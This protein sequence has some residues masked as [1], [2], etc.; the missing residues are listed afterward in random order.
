LLEFIK[1]YYPIFFTSIILFFTGNIAEPISYVILIVVVVYWQ[2]T[3][4]PHLYVMMAFVLLIF[5]DSRLPQLAFVKNLRYIIIIMLSVQVLRDLLSKKYSYNPLLNWAIPFFLLSSLSLFLSP[6][7]VLSFSKMVSYYLLLFVTLHLLQYY[8]LTSNG[9]MLLDL[10]KLIIWIFL[11]GLMLYVLP[12]ITNYKGRFRG[13]MGNPNGLGILATLTFPLLI[14]TYSIVP[15]AKKI[16]T[17]G[18]ICLFI[19][20]VLAGSRTALFSL[21]LFWSMYTFYR[22]GILG[23]SAFWMTAIPILL[24]IFTIGIETLVYNLGLGG[25]LRAESLTSGS[26]RTLA[27][28]IGLQE[29]RD[30]LWLGRGFAYEEVYFA[31]LKDF[32]VLTEHQGGIH[33]SYLTFLM[34]NGIIGSLLF[35]LFIIVLVNNTQAPTY[36]TPLLISALFSATFES[37]LNASLNAFTIYFFLMLITFIHLPKLQQSW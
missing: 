23:K 12:E 4:R 37:W 13:V 27:W 31:D 20:V 21:I 25:Y 34:N 19:S 33:N 1:R 15:Q 5:G 32:F 14:T 6:S 30:N 18:I 35:I 36:T 2:I 17:F 28:E 24:I 26:G 29:I 11:A 22:Y 16:L 7:P 3:D 8:L 9:V 10:S